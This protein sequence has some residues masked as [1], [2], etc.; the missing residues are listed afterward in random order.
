MERNTHV[1]LFEVVTMLAPARG[2][3]EP[4]RV[5]VGL[6]AVL[7]IAALV[8]SIVLKAAV[9]TVTQINWARR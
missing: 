9:T 5:R 1:D 6:L 8:P 2:V 7:V 4:S 3:E